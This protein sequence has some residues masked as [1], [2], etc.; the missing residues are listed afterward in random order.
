MAIVAIVAD[1]VVAVIVAVLVVLRR[2]VQPRRDA[3]NVP[4][5]QMADAFTKVTFPIPLWAVQGIP[6][7]LNVE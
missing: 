7:A 3:R 5:A 1:I 2:P 4:I 6:H